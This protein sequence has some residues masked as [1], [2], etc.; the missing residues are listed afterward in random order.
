MN[1]SRHWSINCKALLT[2]TKTKYGG[3]TSELTEPPREN[4]SGSNSK[5][6]KNKRHDH[7]LLKIKPKLISRRKPTSNASDDEDSNEQKRQGST[8]QKQYKKK[9][10]PRQNG[11]ELRPSSSA[12]NSC[13]NTP[14]PMRNSSNKLI[15]KPRRQGNI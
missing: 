6:K 4:S 5:P 1:G 15:P 11:K 8:K 3:T 13:S 9:Q 14:M 10:R 2:R 7:K 12:N